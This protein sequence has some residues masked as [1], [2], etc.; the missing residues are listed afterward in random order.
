MAAHEHSAPAAWRQLAEV[1]C[2]VTVLFGDDSN[3]PRS[4]FEAQA[5]RAAAP[6]VAVAGGHLF[7]QEDTV[8]AERLVREHL[9]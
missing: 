3:L 4:W 9:A 2:G 1:S 5:E 8:R 6:G 7:V